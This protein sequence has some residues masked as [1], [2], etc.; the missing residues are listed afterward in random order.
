ME[1]NELRIGNSIDVG[2][3]SCPYGIGV[4]AEIIADSVLVRINGSYHSY[5]FDDI[6]GIPLSEE[7]LLKFG[8]CKLW[9]LSANEY[10]LRIDESLSFECILK[11]FYVTHNKF[12]NVYFQIVL[13]NENSDLN[14]EMGEF[15][16]YRVIEIISVN[17]LQNLYFALTGNELEL[18]QN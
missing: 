12:E 8:F 7:W 2:A 1:R 13:R 17:Q 16:C 10:S 14:I 3:L 6:Q 5:L 15:V 4:V 9:H 18:K 11:P